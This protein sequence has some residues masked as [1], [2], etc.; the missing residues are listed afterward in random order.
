MKIIY[1]FPSIDVVTGLFVNSIL[2]RNAQ[3]S[4]GEEKE[5]GGR[6]LEAIVTVQGRG[7]I[8]GNHIL[9]IIS[10]GRGLFVSSLIIGVKL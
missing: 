1:F 7:C 10:M 2:R 3:E 4:T 5:E 9:S 8:T 6:G